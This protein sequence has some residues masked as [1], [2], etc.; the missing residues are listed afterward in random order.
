[1]RK[2]FG[3]QSVNDPYCWPGT[4]CLRNKLGIKES[5]RLAES[6]SRIVSVR[7][8]ELAQ[9]ILPG[10]YNLQH[11]KQFHCNLFLDLYDWAGETR[12]VDIEKPGARFAHWRYV[13]ENLSAILGKLEHDGW[14]HG[15]SRRSF[16]E[17]LA[18]YYSE[19]NAC[20]PFRE[21]NGRTQRAFLRQLSAAANW[22]LDW[23]A[24]SHEENIEASRVSLQSDNRELLMK[25]LDPVVIQY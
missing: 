6:E 21:G 4:S 25:V 7:E 18:Y 9:E 1:M 14:L 15:R 11:F 23:S 5:V 22:R 8:T 2:K 12:Y 10:E 19:I 13:D 17:R 20:H 16:I 24:L 3:V